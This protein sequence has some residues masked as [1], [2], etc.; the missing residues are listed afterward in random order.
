MGGWQSSETKA[1]RQILADIK[2]KSR[3]NPLQSALAKALNS[4]ASAL[5]K[6]KLI[7][8]GTQDRCNAGVVTTEQAHLDCTTKLV[9][10]TID[11]ASAKP[12]R[13][14]VEVFV[15]TQAGRNAGVVSTSQNHRGGGSESIGFLSKEPFPRGIKLYVGSKPECNAGV[16]TTNVQ[17]KNCSTTFVGYALPP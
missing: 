3:D 7:Y 4:S 6:K 9:G 5:D 17:H 8:V 10:Y 2:A 14:F 13:E 1:S 16:V 12:D 11:D 15:G